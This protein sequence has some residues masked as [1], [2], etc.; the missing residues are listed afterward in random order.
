MK[1]HRFTV[2]VKTDMGRKDAA[3]ALTAAL[4]WSVPGKCEFH[5]LKSAPKTKGGAK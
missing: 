3:G 4:G 2:V 1:K 5:L